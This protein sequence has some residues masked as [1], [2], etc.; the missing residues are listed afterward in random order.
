MGTYLNK[1]FG[2]VGGFTARQS[3]NQFT[4]FL[5]FSNLSEAERIVKRFGQD[6]QKEGLRTIQAEAHISQ[7]LCFPFA[8]LAGFA[9]SR[10]GGEEI[11]LVFR[12][13]EASQKEI[14]RVYCEI[15]R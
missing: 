3:K 13:V 5:P 14:A 8:I 15:R 2:A 12:E 7:D 11:D 4:T 6:L 1:H 9:E 10:A